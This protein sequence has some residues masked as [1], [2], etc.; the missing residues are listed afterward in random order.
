ML[1]Q[2]QITHCEIMTQG[3][4]LSQFK[5]H[6]N[7][8][9]FHQ[10]VV[11]YTGLGYFVIFIIQFS[12][13]IILFKHFEDSDEKLY[14]SSYICAYLGTI[15]VKYLGAESII[16]QLGALYVVVLQVVDLEQMLY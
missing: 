6:I 8:K 3:E 2:G 11:L 16:Y 5:C 7:Q 13:W 4:V 10:T 1:L 9:Y 14:V 15:A 12:A